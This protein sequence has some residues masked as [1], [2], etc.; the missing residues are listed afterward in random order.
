MKQ[1]L[2][3]VLWIVFFTTQAIAG[4]TTSTKKEILDLKQ[5]ISASLSNNSQLNEKYY[6]HKIAQQQAKL[7]IL[8]ATNFIYTYQNG[9]RNYKQIKEFVEYAY[10]CSFIFPTLGRDHLDVFMTYLRWAQAETGYR[11]DLI[12]TWK[13]GQQIKGIRMNSK[14]QIVGEYTITI[15]YD[16]KDFGILQINNHNLKTV[17]KAVNKLYRTG[18]IP[19]KVKKLKSVDDFLDIKT[20]LV[21]RSII[22][23][24]RQKRGWEWKHWSYISLDF[25]N[26]MKS[27]IIIMKKQDMYDVN[28]VQKYYHLIPVKTYTGQND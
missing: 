22:E 10:E 23:V 7:L 9:K 3:L 19:F 12:S 14:G 28:L 1:I 11:A 26:K 15:K 25:Y 8:T 17:R 6:K 27:E 18:V 21:S 16:S 24:D 2:C 13:K 5:K 20:N 4:P